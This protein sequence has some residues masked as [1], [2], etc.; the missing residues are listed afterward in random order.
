MAEQSLV[1]PARAKLE[2]RALAMAGGVGHM[3]RRAF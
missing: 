3:S 1:R 2:R